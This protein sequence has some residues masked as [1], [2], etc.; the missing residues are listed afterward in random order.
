MVVL[1]GVLVRARERSRLK[2][3]DLAEKLG[4]PPSY[5]S[6]VENGTRRLDVVEFVHIA[7]ALGADPC[8]LLKELRERMRK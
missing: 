1:G 6:K 7:E 8:E 2:Q 5:L 4:L 3:M